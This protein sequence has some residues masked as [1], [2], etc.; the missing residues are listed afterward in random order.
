MDDTHRDPEDREPGPG[1]DEL[2]AI[3][4]LDPADAPEPAERLADRLQA[5]LDE[6]EE[7]RS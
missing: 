5:D 1:S 3:E 7:P 4:A 2:A 6:S